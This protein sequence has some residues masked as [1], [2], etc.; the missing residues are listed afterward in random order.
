MFWD[1]QKLDSWIGPLASKLALKP[2]SAKWCDPLDEWS[3]GLFPEGYT[4]GF[5]IIHDADCAYSRR[6]APL[7]EA[8]D[9]FG[10]KLTVTAFVFWADWANNGAIWREWKEA[11]RDG[12]DFFAPKAVPLV[13]DK[14]REFYVELA[15]RGHEIGIH[16]PS[17]TSDT[18]HDIVRAFEFFKEVFGHYPKVYTEHSGSTNKEAQANEGSKPE[19]IYYNADLLNDYGPWVWIDDEWG[20]P[21]NRHAQFYDILAVNG[22]PFNKVAEM[23]YGIAKGFLRSGKW[24]EGD[25]D[26]FLAGYSDENIDLLEKNRGL[27]LVYTHLDK[28]WLDSGTRQMRGAIKD[29]LRYLASKN[30]WFVPASTILDRA[31]AIQ[32][33]KVYP[34]ET[35]L[36]IVNEGGEKLEGLTIL[37]NRGRSLCQGDHIRRAAPRGEIVV[38]K[39]D[40]GETLRFEIV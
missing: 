34:D 30:G 36:R 15:N 35:S 1:F 7:F 32:K 37:S 21:H 11:E 28:K 13:D 40:P 16:T 14:E 8:F 9:E 25:G 2:S 4:F 33:V 23:K 31:Q 17:D 6:L 12:G 38:G 10:F 5:T 22:S 20:I 26:G 24:R 27:A 18:R 29:Q 3:V 39:I 19:S